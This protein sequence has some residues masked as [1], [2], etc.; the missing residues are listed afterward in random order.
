M[1]LTTVML[2][3]CPA[4]LALFCVLSFIAVLFIHAEINKQ[5]SGSHLLAHV[6][7]LK[8]ILIHNALAPIS[9]HCFTHS[10]THALKRI[11]MF[12][13]RAAR[14]VRHV[15]VRYL[16][17]SPYRSIFHSKERVSFPSFLSSL[18]LSLSLSPTVGGVRQGACEGSCE[19]FGV[20]WLIYWRFCRCL[21][22][23]AIT[24]NSI[25]TVF[26]QLR[27]P[28]FFFTSPSCVYY[29]TEVLVER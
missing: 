20:F 14:K 4:W 13:K 26:L 19:F 12:F 1:F 2:L 18:S 16:P 29:C 10:F 27:V 22:L 11:R 17:L 23:L 8:Y 6:I 3:C 7:R 28:L 9:F 5:T 15:V 25:R 21:H 24:F